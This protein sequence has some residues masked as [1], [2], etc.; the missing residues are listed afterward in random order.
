[1]HVVSDQRR[2]RYVIVSADEVRRLAP[3]PRTVYL[4][5]RSAFSIRGTR[6]SDVRPFVRPFV[7]IIITFCELNLGGGTHAAGP[8]WFELWI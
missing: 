6:K 3:L 2:V 4:V 7:R 1:M 5:A 8:W